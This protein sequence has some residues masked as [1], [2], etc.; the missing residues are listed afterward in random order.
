M[1]TCF[2]LTCCMVLLALLVPFAGC[3]ESHSTTIDWNVHGMWVNTDGNVQENRTGVDI[4]VSG[5]LPTK[6]ENRGQVKLKLD[7]TWP[8]C[9]ISP[10]TGSKSFAGF[11]QFAGKHN[12]QVFYHVPT[13][14]YYLEENDFTGVTFFLC[15]EEGFLVAKVRD[16]YLVASTEENADTEEI[17]AFY[18]AYVYVRQ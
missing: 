14:L 2:R 7:F 6:F 9:T 18:K 8:G 5:S 16:E 12:N 3:D 15:P 10:D 1:K 11:A 13:W 4:S 17:F